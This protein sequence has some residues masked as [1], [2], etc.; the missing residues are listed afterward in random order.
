MR[1]IVHLDVFEGPLDLLLFLIEKNELQILNIPIAEITDQYLRYIKLWKELDLY[2]AA[3]YFLMAANLLYIKSRMLIPRRLSDG[4]IEIEEDPRQVL[5]QQ[6]L[7]YKKYKEIADRLNERL[8]EEENF[9]PRPIEEKRDKE[10][11]E[12]DRVEL[13]EIVRIFRELVSKVEEPPPS[14]DVFIDESRIL[15]EMELIMML[16]S[17]E[18]PISLERLSRYYIRKDEFSIWKLLIVLIALLYLLKENRIV[19]LQDRPYGR[20]I[21][22]ARDAK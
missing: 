17:R 11:I 9:K 6:L 5:I 12:T 13:Y 21:V 7:E 2:I 22:R 4:E 20:I 16:I 3:E 1:Y 15:E 19:I 18:S 10:M 14:M 8:I